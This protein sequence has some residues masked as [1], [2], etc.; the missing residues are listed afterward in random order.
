MVALE[1]PNAQIGWKAPDFTLPGVDGQTH[2][3]QELAGETGL[4]I[5]FMC[6]HC[7]YVQ[8]QIRRMIE[9]A[10][11]LKLA[12][13]NVVG[14]NANDA[15]SYPEDSFENMQRYAKEEG[16]NFPYLYDESQSIAKAY[17]AVCTPDFFGFNAD[18]TL[19]YRGRLDGSWSG[20]NPDAPQEL[21]EAMKEIAQTG[22]T[23]K[24]QNPSVGCSIKWRT[25]AA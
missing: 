2:R 1:T 4:L 18:L 14:I 7:P 11:A 8:K 15:R 17:G 23:T 19:Q 13:I 3:L 16:C 12:G 10:S 21:L 9:T 20:V 5:I 6:N 25:E 24:P 22:R